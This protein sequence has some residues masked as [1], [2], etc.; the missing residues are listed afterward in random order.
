MT[1]MMKEVVDL[2]NK[3]HLVYAA[4]ATKDGMPNVS[5]KGSIG[6]IGEDKL[7]F[8]EI[9]SPHTIDNL[10]A[11][12]KIALYVLD[13]EH[14]KGCQIKGTCTLMNSGPVF[15]QVSKAL[16]DKMPQLPPAH[17]AVVINVEEIFPY[18]L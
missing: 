9:A 2:I 7:V 11:N 18:K 8:A 12:P 1:K 6:V 15:E 4:T 16:K 13:K 14:N 3:E 5:P 17:Y 10:K